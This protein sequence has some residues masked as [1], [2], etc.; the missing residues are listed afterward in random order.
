MKKVY[1][2]HPFKDD[3][4]GNREKAEI[5]CK[6]LY[7]QGYIPISPLHLFSFIEEEGE[8]REEI[9]NSCLDLIMLADEMYIYGDSEGCRKEKKVADEIGMPIRYKRR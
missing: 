6:E 1:I 2:S 9:L 3:P 5:I 7:E 4:E 8:N